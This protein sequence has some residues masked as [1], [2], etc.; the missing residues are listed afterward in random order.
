MWKDK[1]VEEETIRN[2]VKVDCMKEDMC[3][4]LI[5]VNGKNVLF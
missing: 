4:K 2:D 5:G 1:E 3:V